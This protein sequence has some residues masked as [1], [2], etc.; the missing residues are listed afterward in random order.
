MKKEKLKN[1]ALL[2]T[3]DEKE[4]LS[5]A[6]YLRELL[7]MGHYQDIYYIDTLYKDTWEDEIPYR[8]AYKDTG[9]LDGSD[10]YAD[11]NYYDLEEP[12]VY[13]DGAAKFSQK[14]KK[15]TTRIEDIKQDLQM[16]KKVEYKD[17]YKDTGYLDGS[18]DYADSNYYDL[19]EPPVYYDDAVGVKKPKVYTKT[20][21][22]GIQ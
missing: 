8:D 6:M 21:K 3:I 10:D 18:D 20:K 12:P 22:N 17:A 1:Q 19:E 9:Y 7:G 16:K 13:Y 5:F 11:S 14:S 4:N 15:K 2:N